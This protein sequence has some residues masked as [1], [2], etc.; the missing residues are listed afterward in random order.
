MNLKFNIE[1]ERRITP[2]SEG[3]SPTRLKVRSGETFCQ[4]VGPGLRPMASRY[5]ED[6]GVMSLGGGQGRYVTVWVPHRLFEECSPGREIVDLRVGRGGV[7]RRVG[8]GVCRAIGLVQDPIVGLSEGMDMGRLKGGGN[9]GAVTMVGAIL[10]EC[11]VLVILFSWPISVAGP[12]LGRPGIYSADPCSPLLRCLPGPLCT[13]T[14]DSTQSCSRAIL[15]SSAWLDA[16]APAG[17]ASS[18][19]LDLVRSIV[20]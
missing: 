13:F 15:D 14:S 5:A 3:P 20:Q 1:Q 2:Q 12:G 6:L 4:R 11:M 7:S 8:R 10:G 16:I 9:C 17:R 18:H 19:M